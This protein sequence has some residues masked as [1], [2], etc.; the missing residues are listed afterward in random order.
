MGAVAGN[1]APV[2]PRTSPSTDAERQRVKQLAQE[3]E[4]LLMTQMLREMRRSMLSEDESKNG[5]GNETM[6]DTIDIE[7]GRALSRAGGFG[8]SGV[9]FKAIDRGLGTGAQQPSPG[10]APGD[11]TPAPAA[12]PAGDPGSADETNDLKVPDGRVSSAFGWRQDP[13]TGISEFHRGI[14]VAQPYGQDVRAAAA[15]RIAFAGDQGAYGTTIVIEHP[16]GRQTR[17]AH[18]SAAGVQPGDLVA[19]GQV[20]GQ[21]GNSGRS[22]G[23]HL[24]FEVLEAGQAVDPVAGF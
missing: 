13:F 9:L 14:D 24:H 23:P 10:P 18:L 1:V 16:G 6:T 3:F 12:A 4:A 8:L 7:L 19:A 20:I 11:A 15:G 5:F 22:T 21:S 2:T 17:Y